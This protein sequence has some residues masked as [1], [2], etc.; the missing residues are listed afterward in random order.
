MIIRFDSSHDVSPWR[1][2][3]CLMVQSGGETDRGRRMDAQD[4]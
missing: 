2:D 1:L 3:D 4:L